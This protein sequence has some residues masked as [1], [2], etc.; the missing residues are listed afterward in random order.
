[1]EMGKIG[2]TGI[3]VSRL[4]IGGWQAAGWSSSDD[5]RFIKVVHRAVDKGLNFID[6][7]EEYGKGHSEE[8]IAK[9]VDGNRD[10][11]VI[12]TKFKHQNA[13][14][15]RLRLALER[16]LR[17]LKTDYTD[18]YIY[19]LVTWNEGRDD[20]MTWSRSSSSSSSSSWSAVP[21]HH[22][23]VSPGPSSPC[24]EPVACHLARRAVAGH[25]CRRRQTRRD[26]E[27]LWQVEPA[28]CPTLTRAPFVYDHG[29][30]A[31]MTPLMPMHSLGHA[32]V[33]APLHAGGLR[34]HGVAPLVSCAMNDGLMT[35]RSYHQL[36]CY[37][38][39]MTWARTEG[40]ICAPETSHALTAIIDEAIKAREEGK[41]KVIL[42]CYSGHGLMDLVGYGNYM[43]GKLAD[44][45]LPDEDLAQSIACT[46]NYPKPQI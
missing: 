27:E 16:S 38:S 44:Y 40:F 18:L 15:E 36:K 10:K 21:G 43:E 23:I 6:T 3:W 13:T 4:C 2:K 45:E 41:E 33:P 14:P 12:A 42:A 19:H 1:M 9:A 31:K 20:S 24:S 32:F 35:A 39:A 11:M 17:N 34:Y 29:D 7:A 37:E 30:T 28:A 46:E 26:W 5:S 8:I 25:S 22:V